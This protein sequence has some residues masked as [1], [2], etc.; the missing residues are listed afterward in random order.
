MFQLFKGSLNFQPV[1]NYLLIHSVWIACKRCVQ[2]L[3][4]SRHKLGHLFF[5]WELNFWPFCNNPFTCLL[6]HILDCLCLS[7][8]ISL[9]WGYVM[10]TSLWWGN[11]FS[12]CPSNCECRE[13]G[14]NNITQHNMILVA[15]EDLSTVPRNLPFN[16]GAVYVKS[17]VLLSL[18]IDI[19]ICCQW[20][21]L[22]F[23]L[24]SI[25]C[26]FT[27]FKSHNFIVLRYLLS[28]FLTNVMSLFNQGNSSKTGSPSYGRKIL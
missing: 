15:G 1:L 8:V 21:V 2:L 18:L 6:L 10:I 13:F 4:L 20:L 25:Q 14:E 28:C 3:L 19:F 24:I 7:N 27:C 17:K 12:D 23:W 22:G 26:T 11:L 16:T 9:N 5:S